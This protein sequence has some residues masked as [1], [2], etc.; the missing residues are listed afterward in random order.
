MTR[1][2]EIC[3][4][5][6]GEAPGGPLVADAMSTHAF[7]ISRPFD[8]VVQQLLE[9]GVAWFENTVRRADLSAACGGSRPVRV[10]LSW[11]SHEPG[12]LGLPMEWEIAGD[13]APWTLSGEVQLRPVGGAETRIDVAMGI[14]PAGVPREGVGRTP[15]EEAVDVAT[16][17]F[18]RGLFWTLEA[19]SRYDHHAPGA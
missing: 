2:L 17:S 19:L 9:L 6:A 7:H 11:P 16:Q 12:V 10:R 3:R 13:P 18:L 15:L 1:G 14:A 4:Q 5:G 8:L